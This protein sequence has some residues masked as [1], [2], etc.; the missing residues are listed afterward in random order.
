LS[1]RD[2]LSLAPRLFSSAAT[3]RHRQRPI[4]TETKNKTRT[5]W[6]TLSRDDLDPA[7]LADVATGAPPCLGARRLVLALPAQRFPTNASPGLPVEQQFGP[8]V[9]WS[10]V[11]PQ[12]SPPV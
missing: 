6:G 12:Q 8:G 9:S 1:N 4:C 3:E 10:H 11:V 5:A 2:R 7:T